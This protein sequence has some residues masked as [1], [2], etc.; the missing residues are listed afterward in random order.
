MYRRRSRPRAWTPAAS[1][2]A[3][4]PVPR[5]DPIEYASRRMDTKL[6]VPQETT[7][8]P[9]NGRHPRRAAVSSYG[10]SGTD[11]Y[12]ILEQAPEQ[13]PEVAVPEDIPAEPGATAPLLFHVSSTSADELR[14][15]AGRLTGCKHTGTWRC[16]IWPT[17]WRAGART[18]Q[19]APP[20]LR[21][22]GRS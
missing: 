17:P 3:H 2:E 12:A 22:A 6:F 16:R 18:D 11:V 21:A 19:C 9:T 15:T 7:G 10:V 20:S 1:V 13:A 14:R 5:W 4:G 8:W